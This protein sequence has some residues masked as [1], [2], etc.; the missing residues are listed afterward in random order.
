MWVSSWKDAGISMRKTWWCLPVL[1]STAFASMADKPPLPPDP[2]EN[3]VMVTSGFLNSHPDLRYRLLGMEAMREDRHGDAFKFFRRAAHFADKP[4]QGMVAEML[5]NGDGVE[6]DRALAYAWMDLAAERGYAGF[7]GLRER[8][9]SALDEAG[10]ARALEA[11]QEVRSEE[12]TSALQSLM[13]S[14]YAV[15]CLKKKKTNNTQS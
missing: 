12:H 14:S 11:G 5:W 10:R 13:R 2:T 6:R 1:L 8:Y 9:W 3:P 15:F 4:S 7:L